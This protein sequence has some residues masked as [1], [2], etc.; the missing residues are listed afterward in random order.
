MGRDMCEIAGTDPWS[1]QEPIG[2]KTPT[3]TLRY[4]HL[5]PTHLHAAVRLLDA[6]AG[7]RNCTKPGPG[8]SDA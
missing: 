3:M 2:H 6:P 5:S 8:S 7:G 4:A 1:I